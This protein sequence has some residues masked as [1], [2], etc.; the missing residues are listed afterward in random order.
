MP[1]HASDEQARD[2]AVAFRGFLDWVYSATGEERNEVSALVLDYLGPEGA[3]H[4]VVTRDLPPLE[5]VNLQ[6]ALDAWSARQGRTVDVRGIAL[7]SHYGGFNLQ[8]LVAGDGLPP[9][10][11]SAPALIDLPNG[12]GSTLGCLRLGLL[13][14]TD[15]HGQYVMLVHGPSQQEP[16]LHVEVAGLPVEAAQGLLA[17]LDRLMSELNVY[18]GHLLDVSLTQMGTIALGFG[19]PPGLR[20]EDVV[21]PEQVLSRIERHAIGVAAHR[22]ALLTA[23]QHLKRGLLLFGLPVIHGS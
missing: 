13:L 11:L 15:S 3:S 7:P 17:E 4:S 19:P 14:V 23:G 8:Q 2:F 9:V 6:T 22:D 21:L 18:R 12:P 20:R 16:T 1:E 10:R 5:H